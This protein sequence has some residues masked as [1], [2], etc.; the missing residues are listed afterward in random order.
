MDRVFS[1][2]DRALVNMDWVS[3]FPGAETSFLPEGLFD[4]CLALVRFLQPITSSYRPFQYFNMWS[5]CL[6]FI[7]RVQQR[8]NLP[9]RGTPMFCLISKLK[10]LKPVL[11]EI[12]KKKFS[13][14]ESKFE[15]TKRKLTGLQ[16]VIQ[17]APQNWQLLN[18]EMLYSRE[19]RKVQKAKDSFLQ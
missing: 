11:K 12:N 14:I 3:C 5:T 6:E 8:W 16:C 15:E 10:W 18:D 1:K 7:Q 2:I 13:N 9:L 17:N 19:L 4:H